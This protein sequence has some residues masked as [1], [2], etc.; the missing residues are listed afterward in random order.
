MRLL[1]GMIILGLLPFG[2]S[3]EPFTSLFFICIV[4]WTALAWPDAGIANPVPGNRLMGV[5]AMSVALA[6]GVQLIPLPRSFVSALHPGALP[7]LESLPR[8]VGEWLPLSLAP[9]ITVNSFLHAMALVLFFLTLMRYP[10]GKRE[11]RGIVTALLVSGAAQTAIGAARLLLPGNDFFLLFH[12]VDSPLPSL[13]LTGTFAD[14]EGAAV[15]L[16]VV[17]LSGL[18]YWAAEAGLFSSREKKKQTLKGWILPGNI[19]KRH[20]LLLAAVFVGLILTH[21]R[22]GRWLCFGAV[23]AL[24]T[25]G[26]FTQFARGARKSWRWAVL[27]AVL[28]VMIIGVRYTQPRFHQSQTGMTVSIRPVE[29]LKTMVR[30]FPVLGTGWGTFAHVNSLY[31][32]R[33]EIHLSHA[34][35]EWLQ[36]AIEGGVVSLGLMLSLLIV[37]CRGAWRTWT[38]CND[39][40]LRA[41]SAGF[42]TA[43]LL[44]WGSA[45]FYNPLRIPYLAF[46]GALLMALAAGIPA[47]QKEEQFK[48]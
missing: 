45:A 37:Y 11:V 3:M 5:L 1:Q 42:F 20:W 4:I 46:L 15:F 2:S 41:V 19:G 8:Q 24:M 22:N 13:Y 40:W 31:L 18:G 6:A 35:H 30:D 47:G 48:T 44:I 39:R 21:S 32:H 14:N 17:L 36:V 7:V 23:V 28:M 10:M 27:A 33:P 43:S 16:G 9:G 34:R 26:L 29:E 38:A 12:K 25:M